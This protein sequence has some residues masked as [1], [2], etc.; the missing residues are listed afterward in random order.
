MDKSISE[1]PARV[2]QRDLV[3]VR[4]AHLVEQ[5]KRRD[6]LLLE[7]CVEVLGAVNNIG[8]ENT[9]LGQESPRMENQ[10]K[11]LVMPRGDT[12]PRSQSKKPC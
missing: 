5:K 10:W 2:C 11:L 7:L 4:G 1:I 12:R 6:D 3:D 8:T 9:A